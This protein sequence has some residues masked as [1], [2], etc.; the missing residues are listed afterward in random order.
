MI[1]VLAMNAYAPLTLASIASSNAG[2]R[3]LVLVPDGVDIGDG[4]ARYVAD[5]PEVCSR[6]IQGHRPQ[7]VHAA[8]RGHGGVVPVVRSGTLVM[9]P[10]AEAAQ[11]QGMRQCALGVAQRYM[12]LDR[13]DAAEFYRELGEAPERNAAGGLVLVNP[14]VEG[15]SL[16]V[17]P[18]R[19]CWAH[20]TLVDNV[21]GVDEVI[22]H[23]WHGE[24]ALA[25][26]YLA[27]ATRDDLPLRV[28]YAAPLERYAAAAAEVRGYLPTEGVSAMNRN[29]ER[30]RMSA[31]VRRL[32]APQEHRGRCVA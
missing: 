32:Y 14:A 24:Q 5:H 17:L 13:P 15:R 1:V 11:W 2:E 4:L 21:F 12:Y 26:D 9:R 29:G 22:R 27:L 23:A 28:C 16:A 25:L 19:F 30:S 31:N 20:D 10:L 7:D 3:V 8:L 6:A 18:R